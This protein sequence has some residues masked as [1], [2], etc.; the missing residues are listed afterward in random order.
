MQT[1]MY[2]ILPTVFTIVFGTILAV[3]LFRVYFKQEVRLSSDLPLIFGIT[4]AGLGSIMI[5]Q[6]LF[7][8]GVL[9]ETL[10]IFRI[11]SVFI[12]IMALPMLW[13]LLNIWASSH[14]HRHPHIMV[15]VAS[16][17][18]ACS[19]LGTDMTSILMFIIPVML[20]L[21]I[22][23]VLTFIITW[24]TGRLQEIRSG[25]VAIGLSLM[26]LS[27]ILRAVIELAVVVDLIL[28]ISMLV[29]TFALVNPMKRKEKTSMD[30][31]YEIPYSET[32]IES[33]L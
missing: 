12:G 27:Q 32:T 13:A 25:I 7:R 23:L 14:Q 4:F 26:L 18:L 31:L 8:V 3:Y 11:R 33:P 29:I 21:G 30:S 19:L 10:T 17:W 6:L 24:K 28:A 2:E 20:V 9:E 16:Y 22:S 1:A 5:L 15:A